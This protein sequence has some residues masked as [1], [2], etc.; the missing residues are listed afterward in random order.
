MENL[1]IGLKIESYKSFADCAKII[2]RFQDYSFA[3]IKSKI[4]NHDYILCY[5]CSDDIGV[6]NVISCY[7]QLTKVGTDVSLYELNNRPTTIDLIRNRDAMYD[8]ISAD[9]DATKDDSL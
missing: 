8:E 1:I 3:E 6:K 9:I 7:D 2:R 5:A 4:Q